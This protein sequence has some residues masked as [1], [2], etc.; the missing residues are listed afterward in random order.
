MAN[1]NEAPWLYFAI[2]FW[3]Q[4]SLAK[5]DRVYPF[6]AFAL[7]FSNFSKSVQVL[8][9]SIYRTS[10]YLSQS[11]SPPQF[12]YIFWGQGAVVVCT[13]TP[14]VKDCATDYI[15]ILTGTQQDPGHPSLCPIAPETQY[16][17]AASVLGA[18]T[19]TLTVVFFLHLIPSP[20]HFSTGLPGQF[21][22]RSWRFSSSINTV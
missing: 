16:T 12:Y 9:F 6:L 8:V 19:I 10:I 21:S 15:Q 11:Y 5:K 20:F 3:V 1:Q 14:P 22:Q 2:V 7:L 13:A 18:P 17:N 4:S